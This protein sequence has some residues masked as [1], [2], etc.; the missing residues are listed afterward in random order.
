MS[1]VTFDEDQLGGMPRGTTS[2]FRQE[3]YSKLVS[4]LISKEIV[5]NEQQAKVAL[6]IFS[7]LLFCA[8]VWITSTGKHPAKDMRLPDGTRISP[9]KYIEGVKAGIYE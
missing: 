3:K 7:I 4:F 9:E 2:P 5:K 8:S 6:L 1:E